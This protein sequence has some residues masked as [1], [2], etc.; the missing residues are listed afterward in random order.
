MSTGVISTGLPVD[1]LGGKRVTISSSTLEGRV[2]QTTHVIQVA[3]LMQ[4][5]GRETIPTG[6]Q[7]FPFCSRSWVRPCPPLP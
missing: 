3:L 7:I 5:M 1:Q 2:E 6:T 4:A